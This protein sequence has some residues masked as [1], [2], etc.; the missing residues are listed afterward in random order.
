MVVLAV[1]RRSASLASE[2]GFVFPSNERPHHSHLLPLGLRVM[3]SSYWQQHSLR[4]L[5]LHVRDLNSG[6]P[7]WRRSRPGDS[8]VTA[9][10]GARPRA[11]V[12]LLRVGWRMQP[13]EQQD[14]EPD[15]PKRKK[16]DPRDTQA[17]WLLF[18]IAILLGMITAQIIKRLV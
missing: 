4:P 3:A 5:G 18:A 6:W 1:T 14:Q 10:A 16:P 8:E 17:K 13:H 7:P 9:R 2:Q 12:G 11:S 15:S